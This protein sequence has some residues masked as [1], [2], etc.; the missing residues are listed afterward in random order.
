MVS[1]SNRRGTALIVKD[2]GVGVNDLQ[3]KTRRVNK[4]GYFMAN[5]VEGADEIITGPIS[6]T[7]FEHY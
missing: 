1:T 6:L 3:P 7:A 5:E 4:T 2:V